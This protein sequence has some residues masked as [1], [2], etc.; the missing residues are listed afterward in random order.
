MILLETIKTRLKKYVS[1]DT[2][3]KDFDCRYMNKWIRLYPDC[4]PK[5]ILND[6]YNI[7]FNYLKLRYEINKL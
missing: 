7:S 2:I 1:S 5:Y 3:Y 6:N 4:F